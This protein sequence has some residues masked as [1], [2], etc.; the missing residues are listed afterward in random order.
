MTNQERM[1]LFELIEERSSSAFLIVVGQRPVE[2]WYDYL[3]D[4][5]IAD[6]FMDRVHSGSQVINLSGDSL[7]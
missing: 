4:V 6:A 1:D 5:L 2:D 3:Q 7:R